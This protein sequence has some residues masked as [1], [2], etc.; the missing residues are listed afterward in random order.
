MYYK[1]GAATD[2][3]HVR[4]VNEDR[5][6][7]CQG[8]STSGP[9]AL[10]CV[11]DGMGGL[12]RGERASGMIVAMLHEWWKAYLKKE[13]LSP[14]D[15][16]RELDDVICQVHRKIFL[17]AYQNRTETGTTLSLLF[18]YGTHYFYKQIGDSRIY[19]GKNRSVR[20]ITVDQTWCN[21]RLEEGVMTLEEINRHPLRHALC[22]A[23]GASEELQI[24]TGKGYVQR[25]SNFLLCSDGFYNGVK[26][27][28]EQNKWRTS[29]RP[30]KTVD[31]MMEKIL[32]GD[33]RD[34]ASAILCRVPLWIK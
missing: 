19:I 23:L 2:R 32:R 31:G 12:S 13:A 3:G 17:E 30:Q 16:S 15:I 18:L 8:V 24:V 1:I 27:I 26:G 21:A 11:A 6:L 34:N 4:S 20:Q 5:V 10:L 9:C 33:A 7:A 28:I 25:G 14:D 29:L 22:N